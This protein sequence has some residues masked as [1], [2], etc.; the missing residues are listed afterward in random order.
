MLGQSLI[1]PL[2]CDRGL[3]SLR[4]YRKEWKCRPPDCCGFH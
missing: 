3:K 2:R 4:S 1:D